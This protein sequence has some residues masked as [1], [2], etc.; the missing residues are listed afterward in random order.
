MEKMEYLSKFTPDPPTYIGHLVS[1]F[2][3]L[4]G[5]FEWIGKYRPDLLIELDIL[6]LQTSD[7]LGRYAEASRALSA[8]GDRM[9]VLARKIIDALDDLIEVEQRGKVDGETL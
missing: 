5:S 8:L 4:S 3:E 7:G 1:Q 6:R 2:D 9:G